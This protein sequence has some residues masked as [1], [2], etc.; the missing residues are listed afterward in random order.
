[1]KKWVILILIAALLAGCSS[2]ENEN[3]NEETTTGDTAEDTGEGLNNDEEKQPVSESNETA[4]E[5]VEEK[6]S[7]EPKEVENGDPDAGLKNY[8]PEVGKEYVFTDGTSEV[9]TETVIAENDQY[10]QVVRTLRGN[11]TLQI[12]DWTADEMILVYEDIEVED[13]FQNVLDSFDSNIS[14]SIMGSGQ[15]EWELVEDGVV[16]ATE[17]GEFKDVTVVRKVTNEVEDAET[18]YTRYY[19]PGAGL[20]KEV[21]E[22]TGEQGYKGEAIL[23]EIKIRD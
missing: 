21:F 4:A 5:D 10:I 20:V 6:E 1:M 18:I 11:Q 9:F 13:P 19:A 16:L 23:A 8:R 7:E 3:A 2:V 12:F 17:A 14:E 15:V 22:L